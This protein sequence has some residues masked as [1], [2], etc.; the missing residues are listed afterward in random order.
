MSESIEVYAVGSNVLLDGG[1]TSARVTEIFIRETVCYEVVWWT[2]GTRNCET[3]NAW[4]LLP[5][6]DKARKRRV[7]PVL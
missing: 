6:G 2:D 5:D 4:E 3:V 7:D 1:A